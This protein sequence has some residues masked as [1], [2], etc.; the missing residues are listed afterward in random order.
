[1]STAYFSDDATAFFPPSARFA[2]R[3]NNKAEVLDMLWKVFD[4]AQKRDPAV[5][6][7]DIQPAE[8]KIQLT[9]MVAVTS[10]LLQ[11]PGVLGRR[12]IIWQ[13]IKGKWLIIHMH[14]SGVLIDDK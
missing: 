2:Y 9:G 8:I 3:A 1:M 4:N 14:A 12:T 7:I 13:K 5:P 6:H 10:F 11:D